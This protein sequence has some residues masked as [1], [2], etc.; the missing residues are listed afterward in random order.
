[1]ANHSRTLVLAK[2]HWYALLSLTS[3]IDDRSRVPKE[4][5]EALGWD[6]P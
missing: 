2:A 4:N 1:M 5:T 3:S 6:G